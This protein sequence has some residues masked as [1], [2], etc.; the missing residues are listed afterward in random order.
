MSTILTNTSIQACSVALWDF[1]VKDLDIRA[2]VVFSVF[3]FPL[4]LKNTSIA[5]DA[6]REAYFFGFKLCSTPSTGEASVF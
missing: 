2:V 4:E 1:I 6:V 5:S 3:G